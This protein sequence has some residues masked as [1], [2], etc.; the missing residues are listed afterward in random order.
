MHQILVNDKPYK[1][2]YYG[3]S[4]TN[5][6]QDITNYVISIDKFTDV[7][8]GEVVSAKL[9]L[10]A[11]Y[12]DFITVTNSGKTP[13]IKH[14]DILKLRIE[15][16]RNKTDFYERYLVVSDLMPQTSSQGHVLGVELLGRE[17]FLQK[18]LFPGHFYFPSFRQMIRGIVAFYNLNKG[19]DQPAI[20]IDA[21]GLNQIPDHTWGVFDFSKE[22]SCYDA[23]MDIVKRC[24]LPEGAGGAGEYY[25]MVFTETVTTSGDPAPD[26]ITMRIAP[27]GYPTNEIETLE[28]P[29]QLTEVKKP[30]QASI[31]VVEGKPGTG[32]MPPEPTQF[33]DYLEEYTNLPG[34]RDNV[35]L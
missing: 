19:K 28:K 26:I 14:Y 29:M 25:G 34:W 15:T 5:T 30:S 27:Q 35:V 2:D 12:G 9:M 24:T 23:L 16:M 4:L 11:R 17:H 10:D 6:A 1:L 8:T 21:A 31:V 13:L 20:F 32:S 18:M 7:G 3:T 22:T 33:R